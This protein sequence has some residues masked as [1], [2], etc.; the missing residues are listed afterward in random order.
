[1]N[2]QVAY[3]E[4]ERVRVLLKKRKL[5]YA[6]NVKIRNI[7]IGKVKGVL[8]NIYLVKQE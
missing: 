1:M 3:W 2:K 4:E 8:L 5:F 6:Y 7:R